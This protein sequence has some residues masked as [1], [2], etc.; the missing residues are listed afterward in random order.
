MILLK[1]ETNKPPSHGNPSLRFYNSVQ[2]FKAWI[3]RGKPSGFT[4]TPWLI[5]QITLRP[6]E[7]NPAERN[8]RERDVAASMVAILDASHRHRGMWPQ[9]ELQRNW[10]NQGAI[11]DHCV[12]APKFC[13]DLFFA[14]FR[15][16]WCYIISFS[17]NLRCVSLPIQTLRFWPFFWPWGCSH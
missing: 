3:Y 17:S 10:I 2:Q 9:S 5:S 1:Q 15:T 7:T 13:V 12:E 4:K 11:L 16:K 6:H 8:R 14:I